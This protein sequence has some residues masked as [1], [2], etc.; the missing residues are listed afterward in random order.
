[1]SVYLAI[2][3]AGLC[4]YA[5]NYQITRCKVTRF[6]QHCE[7]KD[8]DDVFLS[9]L[10]LNSSGGPRPD[11]MGFTAEELFQIYKRVFNT[12][13]KGLEYNGEIRRRQWARLLLMINPMM[14]LIFARSLF[15][16]RRFLPGPSRDKALED[17]YSRIM[18]KARRD[19]IYGKQVPRLD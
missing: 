14:M 15:Q 11:H 12:F 9:S 19:I 13:E 17:H 16:R 8:R 6:L 4:A 18:E 7:Q 2:G 5:I 10:Y 1:M 3:G